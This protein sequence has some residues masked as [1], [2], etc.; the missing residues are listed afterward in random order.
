[1]RRRLALPEGERA[2]VSAAVGEAGEVQVI[3]RDELGGGARLDL[4]AIGPAA[5]REPDVAAP[6][7][8][9]GD[10]GG[11]EA[12]VRKGDVDLGGPTAVAAGAPAASRVRAR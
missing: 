5:G 10:P 9:R 6:A 4:D 12:G 7:Q 3:G 11:R 8:R 1:M 2:V